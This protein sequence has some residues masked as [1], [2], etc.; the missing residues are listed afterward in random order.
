[1]DDFSKPKIIFSRISGSEPKFVLD[2]FGFLTNDTGY[3]ITGEHINYLLEQ[4]INPVIWFAFNHF[5][6][7]GGVD[8]E[9]KVN[10]LMNLPVP[11]P[12]QVLELTPQEQVLLNLK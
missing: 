2:P 9:F 3:I 7:G 12:G 10:N 5:Y 4:L 1:M 8:K 6:M 11:K